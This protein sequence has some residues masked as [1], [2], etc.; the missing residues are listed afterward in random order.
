MRKIKPLRGHAEFTGGRVQEILDDYNTNTYRVIVA[1]KHTEA[2]YVLHS[3]QKKSKR[4]KETSQGDI[5]VIL[6]RLKDV[7]ELRKQKGYKK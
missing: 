4:G 7:A 3:F 1:V 5:D 6:K 2:L